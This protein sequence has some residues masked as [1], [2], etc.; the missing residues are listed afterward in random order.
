M[1]Y[2]PRPIKQGDQFTVG[3]QAKVHMVRYFR[4]G[5]YRTEYAYEAQQRNNGQTNFLVCAASGDEFI[6]NQC[7]LFKSASV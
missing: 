7:V 1:S 6:W 4:V 5:D 3:S 2:T